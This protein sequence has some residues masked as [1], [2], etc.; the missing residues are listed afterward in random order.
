MN[1]EYSEA[2]SE[3]LDILKHTEETLTKKIPKKLIEIWESIASKTYKVNIDYTKKVENMNLKPKSKAIISMIYRNYWC[4]AEERKEYDSI[5]IKN[6]E[7]YQEECRKKYNP[8]DIFKINNKYE[9]INEEIKEPDIVPYKE[10]IFQK[11][12]NKIKD[13]FAK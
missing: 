9:Q 10:N 6:E 2:V 7:E 11:I 3:V 8:D 12:L 1:I 13:F 4:D 5:L